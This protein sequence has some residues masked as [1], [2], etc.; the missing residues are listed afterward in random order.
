M[1]VFWT[2]DRGKGISTESS[3]NLG[4]LSLRSTTVTSIVVVDVRPGEPPSTAPRY[5]GI[6][7][8]ND[9]ASIFFDVRTDTWSPSMTMTKT[10]S[11]GVLSLR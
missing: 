10:A 1:R 11:F 2:V 9:S 3:A 4:G 6:S 8:G 7:A 5:N